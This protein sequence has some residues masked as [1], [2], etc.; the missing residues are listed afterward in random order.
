LQNA[1]FPAASTLQN[2]MSLST[3]LWRLGGGGSALLG[4]SKSAEG[5]MVSVRFTSEKIEPVRIE[6]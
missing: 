3:H 2:D 6:K 4:T 1:D 5:Y